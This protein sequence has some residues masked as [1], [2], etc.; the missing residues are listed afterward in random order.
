LGP[1]DRQLF[2]AELDRWLAERPVR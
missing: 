1:R 2:A